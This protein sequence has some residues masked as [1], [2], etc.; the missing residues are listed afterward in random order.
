MPTG[1]HPFASSQVEKH[2]RG[3]ISIS[4][5]TSGTGK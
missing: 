2:V 5:D 4:L 1:S 3:R